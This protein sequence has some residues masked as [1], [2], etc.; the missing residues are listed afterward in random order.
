VKATRSWLHCTFW[1]PAD[2]E[3]ASRIA[4]DQVHKTKASTGINHDVIDSTTIITKGLGPGPQRASSRLA[5]TVAPRCACAPALLAR[6]SAFRLHPRSYLRRGGSRS[7]A[8]IRLCLEHA[9]YGLYIGADRERWERWMARNDSPAAKQ[10]VRDE[11]THGEIKKHIRAA[12]KKVGDQFDT[13]IRPADRFRS[14]PNEQDD[15]RDVA[16]VLMNKHG[17]KG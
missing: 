12:S 8:L 17:S 6:E 9:A 10:A 2:Q 13:A 5:A 7:G 1:L 4:P 16:R 11:F 3:R 15:C 14:A